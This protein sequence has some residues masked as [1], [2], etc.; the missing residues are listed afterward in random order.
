VRSLESKISRLE[1]LAGIGLSSQEQFNRLVDSQSD[2]MLLK[3]LHWLR[4]RIAGTTVPEVSDEI[5]SLVQRLVGLMP[6][7][8]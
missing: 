8:G 1:T 3:V 2:E 5:V 6:G 4:A 7:A